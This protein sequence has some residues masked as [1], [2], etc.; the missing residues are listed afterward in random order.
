MKHTKL[1]NRFIYEIYYSFID[2][3]DKL[4]SVEQRN[5]IIAF[6]YDAEVNSGG[7]ITFFDCFGDV[8]SID[9]VEKA[10]RITVGEKFALNFL[11][12]AAHIHYT[13]ELGYMP[14]EDSDT[15]PIEDDVYYK[16]TPS[17][18][19]LLEIYIFDNKEKIFI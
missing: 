18:T 12:A 16:M 10:L 7:H 6:A 11:S 4:F 17:L 14:D 9:E 2:N 5:A 13:G 8:F 15:D 19:D 1:W 3:K